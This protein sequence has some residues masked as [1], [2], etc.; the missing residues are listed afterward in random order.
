[1][2]SQ[3]ETLRDALIAEA[4]AWK[5]LALL[6]ESKC[7]SLRAEVTSAER[8]V[9]D[10]AKLTEA[11][12]LLHRMRCSVLCPYTWQPIIADFLETVQK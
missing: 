6:L 5:D 3:H 10:A 8:H 1:M 11:T 12:A 2:T 4:Q 7:A 9:H